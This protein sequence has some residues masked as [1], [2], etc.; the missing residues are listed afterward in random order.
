MRRR[1]FAR[2][3]GTRRAKGAMNKTEAAYAVVLEAQKRAGAIVDYK[4]E[5][6]TLKLADDCRLT[7]DFV[8]EYPDGEVQLHEVKANRQGRWHAED[9]ARVKLKVAASLF[10]FRLLVCYPKDKTK[11]H[12]QTE[13]IAA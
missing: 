2:G 13:E 4:Y 5:A 12:F 3:R 8:V 10:P 1:A 6:L 9:D 7:P 11:L